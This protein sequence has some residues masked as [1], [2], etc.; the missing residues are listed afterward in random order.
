M[1][2]VQPLLADAVTT[3][4]NAARVNGAIGG[5]A[6]TARRSYPDWDDDFKDLKDLAVDVVFVSS[7][8]S[9]GELNELDSAG[10]YDKTP[11][12]DIAVRY[13]FAASD[14]ESNG[15]LKN[16]A[17]DPL[18][19]LVETLHEELMGNRDTALSLGS[20]LSANWVDAT[21]R[22]YCDYGKL[23]QGMFL[24]LVRVRYNVS[25]AS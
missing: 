2:A 8:A 14:R 11:G 7:D 18:V 10:S 9:G 20:G 1:S 19:A 23:R 15:R 21:V 24:G 6:F 13:R 16:T 25:K 22:T 5:L 17:V 12:V 3:I 4:I